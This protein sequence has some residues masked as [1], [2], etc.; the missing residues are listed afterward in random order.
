MLTEIYLCHACSHTKLRMETSGQAYHAQAAAMMLQLQLA[1]ELAPDC[2]GWVGEAAL[3]AV[4]LGGASLT[5]LCLPQGLPYEQLFNRS[6]TVAAMSA[7]QHMP[8]FWGD[9]TMRYD[10]D[11]GGVNLGF[12]AGIAQFQG[13]REPVLVGPESLGPSVRPVLYP[14]QWPCAM[15]GACLCFAAH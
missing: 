3:T 12:Q 11:G 9:M 15:R 14:A 5:L 2:G 4:M 10:A 7:L 8:T 13:E 1:L 6:R